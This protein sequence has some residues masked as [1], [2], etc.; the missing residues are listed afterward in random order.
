LYFS[1]SETSEASAWATGRISPASAQRSLEN[2]LAAW[3]GQ[4]KGRGQPKTAVF[5]NRTRLMMASGV[6]K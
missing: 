6:E 3:V 5:S 2:R 1:L 4:R